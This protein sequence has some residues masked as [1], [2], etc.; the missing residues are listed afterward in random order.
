MLQKDDQKISAA[1]ILLI[2]EI[3]TG[4]KKKLN[5]FGLCLFGIGIIIGAGIYAILGIA[6]TES[7]TTLWI[8]FLLAAVVALLTGLSYCEL[9]TLFPKAGAEYYYLKAAYPNQEWPAFVLG[10]LLLLAGCATATTVAVGFGGYLQVFVKLPGFLSAFILMV[11]ATGINL[12]GI[13]GSSRANIILTLIEV[14]G[15]ILVIWFGFTAKIPIANPNFQLTVGT[16]SATALIFFV[17]LGF[18]D[19]ANLAE[20]VNQPDKNIPRAIIISVI[21]TTILYI[22]V[23]IAVMR[24]STPEILSKSKIPLSTAISQVAP[25][26]VNVL[27]SIALF[28]TANTVLI[29]MLAVGRMVFGIAKD[30]QLPAIFSKTTRK[31]QVPLNAM[32][33]T[34]L[35]SSLFLFLSG[36]DE[37][38]SVSSLS[39]L[40]GF[41]AVNWSVIILRYKKKNL[42]RPFRVPLNIG[43]F[44][45]ISGLGCLSCLILLTQFKLKIHL[46]VIG[47]ILLAFGFKFLSRNLNF[48]YRP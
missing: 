5:L 4:S 45:V 44:P 9:A 2:I 1:L 6:A 13:Q 34:L 23:A 48:F 12:L 47:I 22:A 14:F 16:F 21:V 20:E 27:S 35:G 30:K 38:A 43:K 37:L 26:W 33:L 8:S 15:L 41:L 25:K 39:A 3:M 28:S 18:E 32:L 11:I 46:I 7:G 36:L 17:Y 40:W 24:I 42:K 19:I 31:K 29:T 10:F